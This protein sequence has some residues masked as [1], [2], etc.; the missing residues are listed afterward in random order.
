MTQRLHYGFLDHIVITVGSHANGAHEISF[1][2]ELAAVS[3]YY[4][5]AGSATAAS[6]SLNSLY[7][8][9]TLGDISED[10]VLSI[11]PLGLPTKSQTLT[12]REEPPT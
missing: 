5:L 11:K 2:G 4:F 12:K 8:F 9:H 6:N 3:N 1:L 10:D 7:N